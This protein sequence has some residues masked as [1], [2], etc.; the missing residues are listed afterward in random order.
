MFYTIIEEISEMQEDLMENGI[1]LAK[2]P[3]VEKDANDNI[4]ITIDY[5]QNGEEW[6]SVTEIEV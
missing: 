2:K 4:V 6:E 5:L 3:I 1:V